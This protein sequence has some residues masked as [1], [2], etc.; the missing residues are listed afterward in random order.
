MP[1]YTAVRSTRRSSVPRKTMRPERGDT[2]SASGAS[3]SSNASMSFASGHTSHAFEAEL[4]ELRAATVAMGDRCRRA[5]G[6]ALEAFRGLVCRLR[7]EI[8]NPSS[9]VVDD[10]HVEVDACAGNS[11]KC[12]NVVQKGEVADQCRDGPG[13]PGRRETKCGGQHSVNAVD[14]PV[15]HHCDPATWPAPPLDISDGHR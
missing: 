14:A 5:L 2:S 8:E 6:K 15:G 10:D 3:T 13:V 7:Q 11:Q 4:N 12:P 1:P 9:V